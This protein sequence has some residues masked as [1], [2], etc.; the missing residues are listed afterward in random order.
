MADA[1]PAAKSG[2]VSGVFKTAIGG[3]V[4]LVGGVATMYATALFDQVVKPAKPMAN[5]A[6]KADGLNV[7]FESKATGESGWWDFGDGSALEQFTPTQPTISHTYAKTG[8]FNVKLTVRNFLAEEN[9]RTV[10]VEVGTQST[11]SNATTPTGPTTQLTVVPIVPNPT[12]PATF[13]VTATW[14]I[15][16]A[17][18]NAP[19]TFDEAN[20]RLFVVTR[21]PGK[22]VVVNSETG[23]PLATFTAPERTDQ[24]LFDQ[25]NHRVYVT[26]GE[27]YIAVLDAKDPAHYAEPVRVTSAVGAKTGLLVPELRRLYLA[28]SPGEGKKGGAIIWFDVVPA[29]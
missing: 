1:A 29:S 15:K 7:T 26:G 16:A 23:A 2:A 27:G 10:P 19:L 9:D 20:H 6:A 11:A 14:P 4:G 21:M 12:A 3:T 25:A 8:N 18:K 5:F 22:L 13:K 28:V 24:V 17:E